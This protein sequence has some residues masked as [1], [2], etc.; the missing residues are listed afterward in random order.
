MIE[1]HQF[2]EAARDEGFNFYAGVPCSFLTPFINYVIQDEQLTYLAPYEWAE[3]D[4]LDALLTIW[5]EANTRALSRAD[6]ERHS[7]PRGADRPSPQLPSRP[8][9][10]GGHAHEV[11]GS[12]RRCSCDRR[13]SAGSC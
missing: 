9:G 3:I 8:G 10:V 13:S 2:V 1:A 11:R 4:R 5:S 12:P 7:D 6:P